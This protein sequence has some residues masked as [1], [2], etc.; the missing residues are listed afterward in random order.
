MNKR[1][2]CLSAAFSAA[3]AAIAF[4]VLTPTPTPSPEPEATGT[5]RTTEKTLPASSSSATDRY[6]AQGQTSRV[7]RKSDADFPELTPPSRA[8]NTTKAPV[9]S[10]RFTPDGTKVAGLPMRDAANG[11]GPKPNERIRILPA[12]TD[13]AHGSGANGTGAMAAAAVSPSPEAAA[14]PA[15]LIVGEHLHDPAAWVEADAPL[16]RTQDVEKTIVAD[17]FAAQVATVAQAAET[18]GE[19]VERAWRK[20]KEAADW[21]YRQLFGEASLNRD[22]TRAA[23]AALSRH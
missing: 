12:S 8:E 15:V 9:I 11:L 16:T 22:A 7:T 6:A 19:D 10:P 20:A 1:L 3:V 2:L 18:S 4:W 23:N 17:L 13:I 21:R 5:V 14:A